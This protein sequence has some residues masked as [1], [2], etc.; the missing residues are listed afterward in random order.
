MLD[1]HA[2]VIAVPPVDAKYLRK[3]HAVHSRCRHPEVDVLRVDVMSRMR[4][5]D[6]FAKLWTRR[7]TVE[8]PDGTTFDHLS[9]PNVGQP[10][11]TRYDSFCP[12]ASPQLLPEL[13]REHLDRPRH[14]LVVTG[15]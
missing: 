7:T 11:K 12:Q 15:R 4:G 8:L 10:R 3:D 14:L 6:S 9:L 1:L 5:V 13:F 2:E